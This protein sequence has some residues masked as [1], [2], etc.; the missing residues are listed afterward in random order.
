[1]LLPYVFWKINPFFFNHRAEFSCRISMTS[2]IFSSYKKKSPVTL[3]LYTL[4]SGITFS[5]LFSLYFLT[6][7]ICFTIR[8]F[9]NWWSFPLFSWPLHL[10][11]GWCCKE[12]SEVNHSKELKGYIIPLPLHY[13]IKILCFMVNPFYKETPLC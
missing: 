5:F 11:W 3:S 13:S 7:R 4:T 12:K 8:S 6:R 10:I 1:M 2:A 9:S